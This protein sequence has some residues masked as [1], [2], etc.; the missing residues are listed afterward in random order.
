MVFHTS[1]GWCSLNCLLLVVLDATM[2]K[3]Q[4]SGGYF[5]APGLADHNHRQKDRESLMHVG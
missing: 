5:D 2:A 1:F 4:L 3:E